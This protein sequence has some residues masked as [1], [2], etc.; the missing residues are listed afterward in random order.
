MMEEEVGVEVTVLRERGWKR[1]RA[2]AG[3]DHGS[4]RRGLSITKAQL[5]VR[6]SAGLSVHTSLSVGRSQSTLS[7]LEFSVRL[8][9][10]GWVR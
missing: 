5:S 4:D 10:K 9:L 6:D 3:S 7:L 8:A 1:R 2:E